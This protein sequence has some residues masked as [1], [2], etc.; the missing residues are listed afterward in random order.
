MAESFATANLWTAVGSAAAAGAAAVE[1]HN[2]PE[3]L[4]FGSGLG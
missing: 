2:S 1:R 4:R 3:I